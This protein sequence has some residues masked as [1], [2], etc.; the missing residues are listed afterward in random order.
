MSKESNDWDVK[1]IRSRFQYLGLS[2]EQ[3]EKFIKYEEKKNW[4]SD[5]HHFSVWEEWDYDLT[6]FREILSSDQLKIYEKTVGESIARYESD[7][8]EGDNNAS[9]DI[10]YYVTLHDFYIN[11]L[12]PELLKEDFLHVIGLLQEARPKISFLKEEYKRYLNDSRNEILTSHFRHNRAFQPKFLK[13]ALLRHQLSYIW[14][15]YSEFEDCMDEPT[16]TVV[17]YLFN[18]FRHF[19]TNFETMLEKPLEKL[20]GFIESNSKKDYE[21][22]KGWHC[23]VV[24][25]PGPEEVLKNKIMTLLLVDREMYGYQ[26]EL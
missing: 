26:K 25:K 15:N 11:E 9:R 23:V 18:T 14:P 19:N 20:N 7:L 3:A 1:I 4:Y 2:N 5:K 22:I 6:F 17:K 12:I 13:L 16:N 24:N 21:E 8:I 10:A